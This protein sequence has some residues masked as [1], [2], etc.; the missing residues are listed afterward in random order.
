VQGA[1]VPVLLGG[2]ATPA[3]FAAVAEYADGWMP[4]GGSGL[5]EALPEL[6]RAVED[7]GRDPG[8]IRVVPF[9]TVPT[10]AK[11]DHFARLGIDEVVLRVPGGGPDEILAV[12]D[13][14]A[15]FVDRFGGSGG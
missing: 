9:G 1:D 11:L 3:N 15:A 14:H 5:G 4:I 10:D 12:L 7:R 8:A 13:A 6:R 2:A